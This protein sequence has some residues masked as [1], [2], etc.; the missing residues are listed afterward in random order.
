VGNGTR[1]RITLPL[2]EADVV[3]QDNRDQQAR[4]SG[5]FEGL[6]TFC[7]DNDA[8]VL[9]GMNALLSSWQ[10][11]VFSCSDEQEAEQVPFKPQI[12]L[13]D[14]QLDNDVTGLQVMSMLRRHFNEEIP[15]VLISADPRPSVAEEAKSLGFYF[16]KKPV[17]PAALRALIRRLIR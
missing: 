15:G 1:F 5:S 4:V 2:T 17:R 11:D 10:C 8:E 7:I 12:M 16:L 9:A 6:Q 3:K 14:Y 13:A